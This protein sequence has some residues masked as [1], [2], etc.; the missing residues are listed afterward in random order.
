MIKM[1]GLEGR[2]LG[3]PEFINPRERYAYSNPEAIREI[4]PGIRDHLHR[5]DD[6]VEISSG[7]YIPSEDDSKIVPLAETDIGQLYGKSEIPSYMDPT[8]GDIEVAGLGDLINKIQSGGSGGKLPTTKNK[9]GVLDATYVK[10]GVMTPQEF[11]DKWGI[12]HDKYENLPQAFAKPGQSPGDDRSKDPY[13]KD[14]PAPAPL[15]PK[16]ASNV[17]GYEDWTIDGPP[18]QGPIP[19]LSNTRSID[20]GK[21]KSLMDELRDMRLRGVL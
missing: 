20:Q 9:A 8:T 15:A 17:V 6:P 16:L 4:I 12:G 18:E 13:D 5:W 7:P 2:M 21:L 1:A 11:L 14:W 19:A 3:W 10:T